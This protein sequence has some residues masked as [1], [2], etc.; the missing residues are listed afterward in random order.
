MR[1]LPSLAA[2]SLIAISMPAFAEN[3][4]DTQRPDAP[5]LAAYGEH[6][7]GVRTLEMSNPGQID[8]VSP[9]TYHQRIDLLCR[10]HQ[11]K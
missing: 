3:R 11:A 9:E 4:I 1:K 2:A 8:I 5:E 6:E 10:F 7:I